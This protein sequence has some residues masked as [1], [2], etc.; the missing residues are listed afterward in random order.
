MRDTL[1]G[2]LDHSDLLFWL[3]LVR[4]VTTV[5]AE[6]VRQLE[7]GRAC[8]APASLKWDVML[9]DSCS[10]FIWI[11]MQRPGWTALSTLMERIT[12]DI[13]WDYGV[14]YYILLP[15]QN[16]K[17]GHVSDPNR[18]YRR[19]TDLSRQYGARIVPLATE[20]GGRL[21]ESVR[22]AQLAAHRLWVAGEQFTP[23]PEVM[24]AA[25]IGHVPMGLRAVQE[26]AKW[27]PREG[28]LAS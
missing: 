18:L 23:S 21:K 9:C 25:S 3:S 15:N 19:W 7:A 22:H 14:T 27:R 2:C 11:S 8:G 12:G 1:K 5:A 13:Y 10:V 16:V 26:F 20:Y 24:E 4:K 6:C 28:T 17:I